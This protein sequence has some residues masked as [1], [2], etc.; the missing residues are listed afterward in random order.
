VTANPSTL[1]ARAVLEALVA[2]GVTEVVLAP[3]SRNA[4]LAFAAHDAER[5]GLLRLHT[6]TSARPA[7]SP[8]G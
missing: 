6:R 4:P 5:A 2:G 1:L 3:G 8:S 7:S